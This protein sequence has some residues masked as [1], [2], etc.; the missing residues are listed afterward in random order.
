MSRKRIAVLL[1]QPEEYNYER[2]LKGFLKEA[3]DRDYDVCVFS[4]F[5]KYQLTPERCIGESSIFKLVSYEKFDAVVVMADTIQTE[6]VVQRIEEDLQKRCRCPVLFVDKESKYYPSIHID[7]Y[8]PEKAIISHLIEKHGK[9][10]IAFLTG[11]S[12]H[13]HSMVRLNAYKDALTEHGIE[14]DENRIFYGDFWYNSGESLVDSL[15]SEDNT[16]PEAVACANDYMALGVAKKLSERGFSIPRDIAV[17][18]CDCNE[19]G[20]HAPI[21]ITS[22]ALAYYSLGCNAAVRIDAMIKGEEIPPVV[23]DEELFVGESCGC[24]GDSIKPQYF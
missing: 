20:R 17:V 22:C 6:G 5:I 12:W 4:M 11:K 16:L 3:F 23:M 18:G 15:T 10:D 1:G 9:R 19:E 13:P 7:N 24:D 14:V 21:P 8:G 2:F